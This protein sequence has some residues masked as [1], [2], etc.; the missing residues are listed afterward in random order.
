[1]GVF[2]VLPVLPPAVVR[3]FSRRSRWPGRRNRRRKC[4]SPHGFALRSAAGLSRIPRTGGRLPLGVRA[5]VLGLAGLSGCPRTAG[6]VLAD[7]RAPVFGLRPLRV[8]T[9]GRRQPLGVRAPVL[10][11]R[12]REEGGDE[13][14]GKRDDEVSEVGRAKR[15][16]A[17][18]GLTRPGA[19]TPVGSP[20][21]SE[22]GASRRQRRTRVTKLVGRV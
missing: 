10:G 5:S 14:E 4:E 6:N 8:S 19:V 1:M 2:P 18:G 20:A 11:R 7:V 12:S 21:Q 3:E 17:L 9:H 16:H 15:E 13:L 22:S